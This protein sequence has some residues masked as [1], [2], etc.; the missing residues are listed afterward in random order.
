M[1]KAPP[2]LGNKRKKILLLLAGSPGTGK[3]YLLNLLYQRFPDMY[4]VTPDEA[5]VYYADDLGF[6][7]LTE[8]AEQERT[9]VWPFYYKALDLYMEAGKKLVVSEYPFSFKQKDKLQDLAERYG[10]EVV[11]IRLVADFET[12]WQRRYRRDREPGRHLSF[13]LASYHYGDTLTDLSKA[14]NHITREEFYRVVTDRQYDRFQ[15]GE[16]HEVDVSDFAKVDYTDLL[17]L[18]EDKVKNDN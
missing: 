1:S 15:L 3:T 14:T 16:L 8:R 9:K 7:D 18:I 6:N 17:D 12:L 4:V 11:T 10:Y 13:I 2:T 5:K